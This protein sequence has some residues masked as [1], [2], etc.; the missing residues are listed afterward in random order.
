[1][2]KKFLRSTFFERSIIIIKVVT[3]KTKLPRYVFLKFRTFFLAK[4]FPQ[5]EAKESEKARTKKPKTKASF[6]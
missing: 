1:M 5:R 3:K 2:A 4:T 6:W